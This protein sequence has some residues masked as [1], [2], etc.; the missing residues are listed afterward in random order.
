MKKNKNKMWKESLT[1]LKESRNFIYF[2]FL[3]FV[4][5]GLIGFLFPGVFS[6][7]FDEL[8]KK[9]ISQT[10][11]L[12]TIEMIFFIFQNNILSSFLA[13]I[14]GFALGIFPFGSILVNGSLLGY[15]L[16]KAINEKGIFV[17]WRL[18]PH[19][20]FEL[21]AIFIAVGLGIKLGMFW[22][23]KGDIKKEFK[24]RL[25][26]SLKVFLMI[27]L[28]LLIIAAI[29]EGTLVSLAS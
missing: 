11:G 21:P 6:T 24:R 14:L 25:W 2:A 20:I 18:F 3:L 9:L 29:I 15:V 8:I 12:N 22:F 17:I 10:E 28:P 7:Y 13:I 4:L 19:G 16:S 26:G 1:Y 5:G 27:I 23:V